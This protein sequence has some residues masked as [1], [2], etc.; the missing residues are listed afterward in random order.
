[1]VRFA[2]LPVD[3]RLIRRVVGIGPGY[4]E[5]RTDDEP[6]LARIARSY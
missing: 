6:I 3:G 4:G 1:M 2:S 5:F